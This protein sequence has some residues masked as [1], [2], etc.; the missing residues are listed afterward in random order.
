MAD[1]EA[2]RLLV[3]GPRT[4]IDRNCY[5][6][7]KQRPEIGSQKCSSIYHFGFSFRDNHLLE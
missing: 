7:P 3:M 6:D 2:L 4:V 5:P 1:M